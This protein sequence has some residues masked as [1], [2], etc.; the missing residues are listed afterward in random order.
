M[1]QHP[2]LHF[3]LAYTDFRI[4]SVVRSGV[5]RFIHADYE[6]EPSLETGRWIATVCSID[7][8][9]QNAGHKA[10]W[11]SLWQTLAE[12]IENAPTHQST[13]YIDIQNHSSASTWS[14]VLFS[15]LD[16]D[17]IS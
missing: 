5:S 17:L 16:N 3:L 11:S 7:Q 6:Y 1:E 14:M 13:K 2:V 10:T 15:T 12:V 4:W 8:A 9:A